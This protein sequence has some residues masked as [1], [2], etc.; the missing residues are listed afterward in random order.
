[1]RIWMAAS[2]AILAATAV[3]SAGGVER[4]SQSVGILFEE[5]TYAEVGL[6]FV[7]PDVSGV[8][9]AT[10][11]SSGDVAP[12]FSNLSL[13]YRQDLTDQLSLGVILDNHIGADVFYPLG[14]GYP[15]AGSNAM[16]DG[17][18]FTALLRYEIT[19]RFSAYGG[20]RIS[21]VEGQV[22]L[23]FAN[24]YTLNA[25]GGTE[26][27]YVLGVAYE[28]PDIALR[29]A[30]TYN[31][32]ID[33]T[34]AATESFTGSP[35]TGSTTFETTIPQSVNLEFQT[36]VAAD[37]L[38]F[39]SI[40]WVDW[41]EF[42]ITPSDFTTYIGTGK[43]LVDY[44]SDTTTYTLGLGRRFNENWAGAVS[45]VYETAM[46]G[47]STNLGPTDGRTALGVGLTWENGQVKISGGVQYSWI[48]DTTTVPAAGVGTFIDNTS[49][50]AG[51]RIG[52]QF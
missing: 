45:A 21:Q 36:G 30:L 46:G 39:G 9:S 16:V 27:G 11:F 13:S 35:T 51:V 12:S 33:H 37:T 6:S 3:A 19:E 43:S 20:L 24:A 44:D 48:G 38:V 5:G 7:D 41:S 42:D 18:A 1:M 28:I 2:A 50:A 31:S 14:T 22:S 34:F 40:R 52:Y 47:V 29:V 15:I 10:T 25:D 26:L 4:S 49:I 17:Q 32:A 23:P 8:S